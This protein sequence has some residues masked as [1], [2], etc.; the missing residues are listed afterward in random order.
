MMMSSI[1]NFMDDVYKGYEKRK[2]SRTTKNEKRTRNKTKKE[3]LKKKLE[4]I[5]EIKENEISSEEITLTEISET[6]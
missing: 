3:S 4:F 2:N 5:N 1:R 6:N